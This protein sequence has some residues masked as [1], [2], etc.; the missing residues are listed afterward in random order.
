MDADR[1]G[2]FRAPETQLLGKETRLASHIF[3][4]ARDKDVISDRRDIPWSTE[5]VL[6]D[7]VARLQ[8]DLND[9]R[10]KSRYLRMPGVR[11]ALPPP[12]HVNLH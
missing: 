7:R 4:E 1:H 11:D 9:M 10:A 6:I 2:G 12:R 5:N 3:A 8:W